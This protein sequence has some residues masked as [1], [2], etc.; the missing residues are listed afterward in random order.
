MDENEIV[1]QF[2][3]AH[4]APFGPILRQ[5]A[6][7]ADSIAC[8]NALN[9][10]AHFSH[11]PNCGIMSVCGLTSL[12][13]IKYKRHKSKSLKGKKIRD[14]SLHINCLNCGHTDIRRTLIMKKEVQET[15]VRQDQPKRKK[16]KSQLSALLDKKR[17]Q[18]K[19][20]KPTL[21]LM[22]FMQ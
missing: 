11:C 19:S 3:L 22:S 17:E 21:D 8:N 20:V 1:H 16:N 9:Y 15:P 12:Y 14:R 13:S 6:V 5:H 18:E 10:P 2:N 7:R 4:F